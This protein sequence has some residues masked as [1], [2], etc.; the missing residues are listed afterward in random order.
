[1]SV[2]AHV[3]ALIALVERLAWMEPRPPWAVIG[4]TALVLQG[5]GSRPRD[6]AVLCDGYD[7]HRI[8]E[9]CAAWVAE[10]VET[11]E[12]DGVR[13]ELGRLRIKG[14]DVRLLGDLRIADSSD[15]WGPVV[16]VGVPVGASFTPSYGCPVL[17]LARL[18]DVDAARGGA[19]HAAIDAELAARAAGRRW[20]W[21]RTIGPVPPRTIRA[22]EDAAAAALD[23]APDV[24]GWWVTRKHD[25][26]D[27][28]GP[29]LFVEVR[30][31][32]DADPGTG[33]DALAERADRLTYEAIAGAWAEGPHGFTMSTSEPR[34]VLA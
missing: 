13:G 19:E 31:W 12:R 26:I 7:A 5:L 15:R 28:T 29:R 22:S 4:S 21:E 16:G 17:S 11:R 9:A 1:M 27:G 10:P 25:G 18:R 3:P 8:A 2:A 20:T 34:P 14:S 24:T 6:V 32:L 33:T 30:L 23:A